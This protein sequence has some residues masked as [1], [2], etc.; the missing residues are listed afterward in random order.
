MIKCYIWWAVTSSDL[1]VISAVEIFTLSRWAHR[2]RSV[3]NLLSVLYSSS[4]SVLACWA[5]Q[6][7]ITSWLWLHVWSINCIEVY[8]CKALYSYLNESLTSV[9]SKSTFQCTLQHTTGS[10]IYDLYSVTH[11]V[12]KSKTLLLSLLCSMQEF[13]YNEMRALISVSWSVYKIS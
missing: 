9:R 8:I 12:M 10:F 6:I 7:S 3:S 2:S 1:H 4:L 5:E 11:H 13:C